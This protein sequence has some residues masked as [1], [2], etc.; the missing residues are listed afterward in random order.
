MDIVARWAASGLRNSLFGLLGQ[1]QPGVDDV[2]ERTEE[3]RE[4]I[5]GHLGPATQKARPALWR[6]VRYAE[7]AQALWYLRADV[8]EALSEV[9][10]EAQAQQ[11][12]ESIS[13]RFDGLLPAALVARHRFRKP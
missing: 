8:M 2:E 12:M 3:I 13:Q 6:R 5:L 11:S 4:L 10:G 9:L 7:D 1:R